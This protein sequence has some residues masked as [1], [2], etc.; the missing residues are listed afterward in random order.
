[1]K[2]HVPGLS[3]ALAALA[4]CVYGDRIHFGGHLLL[5]AWQML[6][7]LHVTC[8]LRV[9]H[10]GLCVRWDAAMLPLSELAVGGC[11]SYRLQSKAK[12]NL[13]PGGNYEPGGQIPP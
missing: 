2:A 12:T 3:L 9:E 7:F 5:P 10:H 4:C 6:Y 1:M 11:S 8:T 13:Q